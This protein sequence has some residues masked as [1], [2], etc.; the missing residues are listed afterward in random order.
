VQGRY[1]LF[2]GGCPVCHNHLKSRTQQQACGGGATQQ[3]IYSFN[4]DPLIL[5]NQVPEQ[6]AGPVLS[7]GQAATAHCNWYGLIMPSHGRSGGST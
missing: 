1:A 4:K 6:A 5:F 7:I 2:S 3:F